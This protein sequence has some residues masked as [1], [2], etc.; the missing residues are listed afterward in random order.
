[1]KKQSNKPRW[2]L[3]TD[4]HF[5]CRS[6]SK[7]FHKHF[8]KFYSEVF[9]PKL[10][11]EKV[12]TV[13]VLGDFFDRR[14]LINFESLKLA[15]DV[16]FE[17]LK[18]LGI[19]IYM[20][21]GNH[22]VMYKNT[23]SVNSLDLLVS[24]YHYSNVKV[25]SECETIEV[26]GIKILMLPWINSENYAR[27]IQEI[28]HSEAELVF[29]HLEMKGFEYHRGMMSDRGHCD[30]DLLARYR[31]VLS[32]HYHHRSSRDNIHYLGTPYEM[33]WSD[34]NDPKGFH[35]F[36]GHELRFVENPNKV[37]IRLAYNDANP[38][39]IEMAMDSLENFEDKYLKVVIYKKEN[40]ILFERFIDRVVELNPTDLNI[41]DETNSV[42]N[43]V[44][45]LAPT[46]GTLDFIKSF[47]NDELKTDLEKDRLMRMLQNLYIESAKFGDVE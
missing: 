43:S 37:F 25:F 44:T 16:F 46:Q 24:E 14:K 28:T 27:S 36:D 7:I 18:E 30:A 40:P 34:Y 33:N 10:I 26:D 42:V 6:D 39:A 31:F 11:E 23:N 2:A 5:G 35:L 47:V 41:L 4:Q 17:P 3:I 15:R 13:F 19:K 38:K 29:S 1:M 9:I 8:R 45:E 20:I 21:A 32:G 12:T 22:D